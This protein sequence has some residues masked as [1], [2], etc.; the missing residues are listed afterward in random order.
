MVSVSIWVFSKNFL[1]LEHSNVVVGLVPIIA[2]LSLLR[3]N[4][5]FQELLFL[6]NSSM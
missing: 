3:E 1:V 2:L 5:L 4:S 6:S